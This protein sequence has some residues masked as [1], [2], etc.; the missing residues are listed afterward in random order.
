MADSTLVAV[1]IGGSI[2]AIPTITAAYLAGR[3]Q[4]RASVRQLRA[5][6]AQSRA[7]LY[8][9]L[10]EH[11]ERTPF[12]SLGAS[13]AAGWRKARGTEPKEQSEYRKQ[14]D[15]WDE[16]FRTLV[17]RVRLHGGEDVRAAARALRKELLD[18]HQLAWDIG[19]AGKPEADAGDV[20]ELAITTALLGTK[21]PERAEELIEAMARELDVAPAR[22]RSLRRRRRYTDGRS[23][24]SS[25]TS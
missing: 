3:F 4:D 21:W 12:Q 25:S 20:A 7:A 6:R 14:A 2:A 23:E 10:T 17:S 24:S 15:E 9:E 11:L 5:E 13:A 16:R 22:R 18:A 1:V 8:E 19:Q